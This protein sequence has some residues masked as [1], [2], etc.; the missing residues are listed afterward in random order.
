MMFQIHSQPI[1]LSVTI[2]IISPAIREETHDNVIS[3]WDVKTVPFIMQPP[4]AKRS[5]GPPV[6]DAIPS[7]WVTVAH[8]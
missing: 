5:T 7:A 6:H 2:E 8:I 3:I 1:S 4:T